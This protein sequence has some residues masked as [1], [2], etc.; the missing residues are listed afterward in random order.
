MNLKPSPL[1]TV[2]P[3]TVSVGLLLAAMISVA[4]Q[5]S[6]GLDFASFQ[7]IGQR[8]IFDPNRV[9]HRRSSGP[10]A[11]VV[12]SFSFVGT[13]SYAK[14]NFAFFD[15][16]SPDFRKVLELNGN[17]ADFKV[18]AINPRSVTLLSGTNQM[19]LPLG[20]QMYRDDDGHWAVSTETA[21]Y[22]SS[23][24]SSGA[25]RHSLTRRRA[26][27]FPAGITAATDNLPTDDAN[28]SS[29]NG[30]PDA[31]TELSAPVTPPAA[32]GSDALTRLMQRRAQEE[33]QLGQGQ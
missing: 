26:G 11:H 3:A 30:V 9:P 15:G 10:A 14:G 31:G 19:L 6:N 17:I 25:N 1:K 23:G 28:A 13:M 33:Q 2:F 24:G 32:G 8:N 21:S 4:A 12:D 20:T 7:I 27:G 29:P 16:T 22:A 18:T 5:S